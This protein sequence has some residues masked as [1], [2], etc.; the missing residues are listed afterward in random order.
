MARERPGH[1]RQDVAPEYPQRPGAEGPPRLQVAR[2][3]GPGHAVGGVR[4]R[5]DADP[6][7]I[8]AIV[9]DLAAGAERAVTAIEAGDPDGARAGMRMHLGGSRDRL[10]KPRADGETRPRRRPADTE[11]SHPAG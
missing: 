10:L 4:R 1:Q 2:G 7:G 5:R 8:D 3:A 9:R 11:A 6:E